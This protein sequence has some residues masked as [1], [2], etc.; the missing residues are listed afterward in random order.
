MRISM[1]AWFLE[2]GKEGP[3]WASSSEKPYWLY[4]VE[5]PCSSVTGSFV[6]HLTKREDL[7]KLQRSSARIVDHTTS[8]TNQEKLFCRQWHGYC[9]PQDLFKSQNACSHF[10]PLAQGYTLKSKPVLFHQALLG[11]PGNL[12]LFIQL[13]VWQT[14]DIVGIFPPCLLHPILPFPSL[15]HSLGSGL[16]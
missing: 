6:T 16:P 8:H 12:L 5:L 1:S 15:P 9:S 4:E 2:E 14:S 3:L 7:C 11:C 13:M 10:P